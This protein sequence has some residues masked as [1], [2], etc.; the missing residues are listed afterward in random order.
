[1]PAGLSDFEGCWRLSRRIHDARVGQDGHAEG[2]MELISHGSGLRYFE[3]VLLHL[4]GQ[5]PIPGTRSYI[6][7][8]EASGISVHFDDG[9]PFHLI[10]MGEFEP[11]ALHLCDPDRYEVEYDF[12]DW[13]VWG[14]TWTVTG[15]RKDYRMETL[16]VR[17]KLR[18]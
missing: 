12:A 7:R 11:R 3:D 14:V 17:E 8:E 18:G 10:E 5:K 9:R 4:P 2:R 1:M 15:P 16:F 6:W 13:P